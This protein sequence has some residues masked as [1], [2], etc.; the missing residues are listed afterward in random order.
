VQNFRKQLVMNFTKQKEDNDT[1][2]IAS[3]LKKMAKIQPDKKAVIDP[4]GRYNYG[5]ISQSHLSFLQLDEESDC[6]AHGFEDVGITRGTRA[7]LMVKPGLAFFS[8]IFALFKTGAVPVVVDPGMGIRRMVGCFKEGRPEAFIGIPTAHVIR[9]IYPTF[10]STVNTWITVGRRWFWGGFTL[11]QMHRFSSKPY[12]VAKTQKDDTAAILFTTG[13]TGP[14]K[15]VVYTHGNFDAQLRSIR[16]HL[17]ITMDEIDLSTF[18]LFALFWPALGITSV[19]PDMD[20]TKPALANPKKI[21]ETII[22]HRVTSM[23]ASPALLNR[24][25]KYNKNKDIKLPSLKRVISAGAPVSPSLIERFATMLCGDAEVHTPY[26]ATEAVPVISMSSNEILSETRSL[27]EKGYGLCIGRPIN[28]VDVQ[29]IN[30]TDKSINKWS[31]DILVK[32]G[33]VGEIT[34]S[35]DLVTRQYFEQPEADAL[36]KI[37][38]GN[39]IWHRMG[40]LGRMDSKGRI[41]FYGR[42]SHRVVIEDKILFTI[43]CEAIF[44][45]HPNVFRSALVGIGPKNR[46]HPV[47]CIELEHDNLHHNKREIKNELLEFAQQNELT[48]SIKTILFHKSFPVDIRHNSKIFRIFSN[49]YRVT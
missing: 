28:D 2:N 32:D 26:G 1:L 43:P 6:L 35:G 31:D 20:P 38:D 42:K 23:F 45:T 30:I 27:S 7:I 9:T 12:A 37:K 48:S 19:I 36:A 3:R 13:S 34:V 24:I 22:N 40:D 17:G 33:D 44:N 29:I 21:I 25:G 41:W 39:T 10:F 8:V 49:R 5:R 18:P 15:G 14:A 11:S 46:Q 16:R 4:V 47:I